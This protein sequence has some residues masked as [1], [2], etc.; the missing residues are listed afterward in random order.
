VRF[1][2][3]PEAEIA[4]LSARIR[5]FNRTGP[6]SPLIRQIEIGLEE[7]DWDKIREAGQDAALNSVH[8]VA[9]SFVDV[10][11]KELQTFFHAVHMWT[12]VLRAHYHY[13]KSLLDQSW[14]GMRS[15]FW[16]K[17]LNHFI[18]R[19]FHFLDQS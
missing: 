1:S 6:M 17:L 7:N 12:Y 16:L 18:G 13:K 9:F 15:F 14:L 2:P 11:Y 19:A 4:R 5:A 8:P 10:D 3:T